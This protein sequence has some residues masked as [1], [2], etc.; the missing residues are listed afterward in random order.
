MVGGCEGFCVFETIPP[1]G[2]SQRSFGG[3]MD[4]VG[5]GGRYQFFQA[6]VGKKRQ[7]DFRIAGQGHA[8]GK[9]RGAYDFDVVPRCGES[10][11]KLFVGAHNPVYLRMPGITD[12]KNFHKV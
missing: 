5:R 4:L 12:N 11:G 6:H 1:G 9:I 3:D 2:L 8:Q 7:A 10:M